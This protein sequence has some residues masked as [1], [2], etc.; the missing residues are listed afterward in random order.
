M[1]TMDVT[2][3][4]PFEKIQHVAFHLE[5]E[6]Q[7]IP[8][9]SDLLFNYAIFEHTAKQFAHHS[10]NEKIPL[11]DVAG[12]EW[13]SLQN[14]V[15]PNSNHRYS[16]ALFERATAIVVILHHRAYVLFPCITLWVYIS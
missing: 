3:E 10:A 15:P 13:A 7:A 6:S 12:K 8:F 11:L 4:G 1:E 2:I 5:F 14:G 16:I 9:V